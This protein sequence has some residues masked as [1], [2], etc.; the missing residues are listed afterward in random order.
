M[1]DTLVEAKN[2]LG[3]WKCGGQK[4]KQSWYERQNILNESW[5]GARS[6]LMRVLLQ[7]KFAVTSFD[8]LM[9]ESCNDA[10]AV[11]RCEDCLSNGY[12]CGKCDMEGHKGQLFRDRDVILNG[13]C[14]PI[15][16]T[17]S[18]NSKHEWISIG[19][20]STCTDSTQYCRCSIRLTG[21]I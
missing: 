1:S 16:S 19:K 11:I 14:E 4:K 15:P 21:S 8:D 12:V 6:D 2:L 5:E 3:N 9:C 10:R 18:I 7:T 13:F 20:Y 17:V